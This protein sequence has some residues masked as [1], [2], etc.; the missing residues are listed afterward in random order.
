MA[1]RYHPASHLLHRQC[2]CSL[3][4]LFRVWIRPAGYLRCPQIQI[5]HTRLKRRRSPSYPHVKN[6]RLAYILCAFGSSLYKTFR[7]HGLHLRA[8][9]VQHGGVH[10]MEG[11][12]DRGRTHAIRTATE[13][14]GKHDFVVSRIRDLPGYRIQD[15]CTLQRVWTG[16]AN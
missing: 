14:R 9:L 8:G 2:F 13:R 1:Q 4:C 5:G 3:A 11:T 6:I 7:R 16:R 10:A 15:L 12:V